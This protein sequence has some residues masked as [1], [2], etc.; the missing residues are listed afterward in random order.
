MPRRFLA[1]FEYTEFVEGAPRDFVH[2][3]IVEARSQNAA[4]T[5]A[6][7]HFESLARQS[8]VGWARVLNRCTIALVPR[9][10]ADQGGRHVVKEPEIEP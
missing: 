4:H 2:E 9:D 10:P 5:E 7:R 1:T 8:S 3:T 6:L